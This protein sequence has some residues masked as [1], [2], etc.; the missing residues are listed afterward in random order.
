MGAVS[1]THDCILRRDDFNSSGPIGSPQ[2]ALEAECFEN[3]LKVR[4]HIIKRVGLVRQRAG[5]RHFDG[6]VIAVGEI[7]DGGQV[8]P[9]RLR[10]GWVKR[11]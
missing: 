9:G 1:E 11:L 5:T 3:L 2:T 10:D 7:Q 8:C 6:D 4:P